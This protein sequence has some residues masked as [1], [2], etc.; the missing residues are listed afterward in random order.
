MLGDCMKNTRLSYF[1]SFFLYVCI[2]LFNTQIIPFLTYCGYDKMQ[3]GILISSSAF[4]SIFLQIYYANVCQKT[5]KF[6]RH[7]IF[8]IQMFSIFGGILFFVDHNIF[9]FHLIMSIVCFSYIKVVITLFDSWMFLLSQQKIGY[10]KA[11]SALGLV[12]AS[13][14]FG[15]LIDT[16]H[17]SFVSI[18]AIFIGVLNT[19][20]FKKQEA[21]KQPQTSET[22]GKSVFLNRKY[23]YFVCVC[24]FV[25]IVGSADQY[26]VIQKMHDLQASSLLIGIK[27]ALQAL[28]EIPFYLVGHKIMKKFNVYRLL[29]FSIVMYGI[30][31][32]LY[33]LSNTPIQIILTACLQLFTLPIIMYASKFIF[34]ALQEHAKVSSQV[35]SMALYMGGS[36]A[37]TPLLSSFV[38]LFME[39]N[40]VLYAYAAFCIVPFVMSLIGYKWVKK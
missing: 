26:V 28:C 32:A 2:T 25:F 11:F 35:I 33:G 10:V 7:T 38:Y 24:F 3:Q 13:P 17:Y 6:K 40:M 4:V 22:Q 27:F 30:K 15:L 31:F 14:I 23:M 5:A 21:Y 37:I 8:S 34:A 36:A 20:L 29:S 12:V 18:L 9:V 19:L 1:L 39:Q 16:F